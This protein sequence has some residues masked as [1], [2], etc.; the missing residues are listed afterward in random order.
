MLQSLQRQDAFGT[1]T[2]WVGFANFA[3]L[4]SDPSYL[5]SFKTTAIFS[6]LVAVVGIAVSLAAGGLRRPRHSRPRSSTR[7]C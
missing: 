3:Q 7:R 6:M 4:F 2:E 5:A 1:S